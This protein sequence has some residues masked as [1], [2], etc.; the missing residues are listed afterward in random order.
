MPIAS[1][2]HRGAFPK[3]APAPQGIWYDALVAPTVK[4][5]CLDILGRLVFALLVP[6][7]TSLWYTSD[8]RDNDWTYPSQEHTQ[9]PPSPTPHLSIPRQAQRRQRSTDQQCMQ[10]T[11]Q[12]RFLLDASSFQLELG[13]AP[14]DRQ[15]IGERFSGVSR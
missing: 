3:A 13:Q 15:D 5:D 10:Y 4:R 12:R 2:V 7:L 9:Q 14:L 6:L 1:V 8:A 11:L